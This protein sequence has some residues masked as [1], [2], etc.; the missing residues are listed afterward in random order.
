MNQVLEKPILIVSSDIDSHTTAPVC[1]ELEKLGAHY[2]LYSSDRIMNMQDEFS[3]NIG[4]NTFDV[5]LNETGISPSDI[6][7]AWYRKPGSFV[8]TEQTQ[9]IAKNVYLRHEISY[10]HENI[11]YLYPDNLWLNSPKNIRSSD[12]K[13]SQL[14]LAREMGFEIPETVAGNSWEAIERLTQKSDIIAKMVRGVIAEDNSLKA[15]YTTRLTEENIQQL[16]AA[17]NPFPGIYQHY[18]KKQR[19][20]RVTVV[21][22]DVFSAAIYTGVEAKDDWRKLQTTPAVTFRREELPDDITEKCALYVSRLNLAFGALDFIEQDDGTLY[23]LECNPNG[24]YQWLESSLGLP[25][26]NSIACALIN[27]AL[28]NN[29]MQ[30]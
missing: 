9:D 19:E 29:S 24:Q 12:S 23:F 3:I 22:Q 16:A 11:W 18:K 5:T 6:A 26:S 30:S 21:G 13:L 7:A 2:T 8:R 27:I 15:M 20:W 14:I 25:I 17:A 10:M 4:M 28:K 1:S